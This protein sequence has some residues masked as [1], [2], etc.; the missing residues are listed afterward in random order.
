MLL[1]FNTN[2]FSQKSSKKITYDFSC[3]EIDETSSLINLFSDYEQNILNE[4]V[5]NVTIK[6]EIQFGVDMHNTCKKEFKFVSKGEQLDKLQILLNR[7]KRNI[8]KPKGFNYSIHLIDS[9]TINAFTAGGNIYVTTAMFKFCNND[10]E[11]ACIIGHEIAHNELGHINDNLKR[12]KSAQSL[13]GSKIGLLTANLGMFFTTPFNQ[14]KEVHCDFIG[15]DLA[16][17]S[18]FNACTVISLWNRMSESEGTYNQI[19]EV[20]SSHPY[21]GKRSSCAESHLKNNYNLNCK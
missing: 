11:L 4:N 16:V 12:I 5:E 19:F 1:N 9:S 18:G 21:S 15:I 8:D 20:F 10:D 3:V 17:R 2:C 7:L 6:E 13:L 14:K